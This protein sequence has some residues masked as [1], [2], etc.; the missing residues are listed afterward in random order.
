[1]RHFKV[2]PHS[3]ALLAGA[4]MQAWTR[5]LPALRALLPGERLSYA[6]RR[7]SSLQATTAGNEDLEAVSSG[8][9]KAAGGASQETTTR[10]DLEA[11]PS[12]VWGSASFADQEFARREELEAGQSSP[13]AVE[14]PPDL[15][16]AISKAV[17]GV[18]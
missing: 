17:A 4:S 15:A 14:V 13:G 12:E 18:W 2:E 10:E 1:L 6:R 3:A 9:W 16:E 7:V 5:I 11:V 8:I